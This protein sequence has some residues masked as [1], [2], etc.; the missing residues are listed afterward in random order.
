M[1]DHKLSRVLN[2]NFTPN[3]EEGPDESWIKINC[4]QWNRMTESKSARAT[5]ALTPAHENWCELIRSPISV[6]HES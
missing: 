1:T 4:F 5:S 2:L 3:Q 6:C